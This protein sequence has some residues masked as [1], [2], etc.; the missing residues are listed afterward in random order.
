M[1]V[2]NDNTRFIVRPRSALPVHELDSLFAV[3]ENIEKIFLIVLVQSVTQQKYVS[4]IVFHHD[5][6]RGTRMFLRSLH[7]SLPEARNAILTLDAK[8]SPC[9]Y[10]SVRT[11]LIYEKRRFRFAPGNNIVAIDGQAPLRRF[12]A[13]R[14]APACAPELS[15]RRH[16]R[17]P[18]RE[19]NRAFRRRIP[20]SPG[21]E[22]G[23]S[24]GSSGSDVRPTPA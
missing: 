19:P 5:D 20:S 13:S 14:A 10:V 24:P 21:V 6:F 23:R 2:Q 17:A 9:C 12:H 11:S 15:D 4:G 1:Q 18:D 3:A 16:N 8:T 7:S 22:S